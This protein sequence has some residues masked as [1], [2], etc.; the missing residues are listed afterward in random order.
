M[1]FVHVLSLSSTSCTRS[2]SSH[3]MQFENSFPT[4]SDQK[5]SSFVRST[6]ANFLTQHGTNCAFQTALSVRSWSSQ[7]FMGVSFCCSAVGFGTAGVKAASIAAAIHSSIGNGESLELQLRVR[8]AGSAVGGSRGVWFKA[9]RMRPFTHCK[10]ATC[11]AQRE[12]GSVSMR[13]KCIHDASNV[14]LAHLVQKQNQ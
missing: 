10:N 14:T 5:N 1:I 9:P 7:R 8:E 3:S 13:M 6:V 11:D 2:R 4:T 12:P